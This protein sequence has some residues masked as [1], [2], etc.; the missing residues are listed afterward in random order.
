MQEM[1]V[2]LSY[3]LCILTNSCA[4]TGQQ[5]SELLFNF[6]AGG[7]TKYVYIQPITC[8]ILR[9]NILDGSRLLRVK[10]L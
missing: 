2:I 10:V 8:I 5:G 1:K 3:F 4:M 7:H 6:V 9:Y